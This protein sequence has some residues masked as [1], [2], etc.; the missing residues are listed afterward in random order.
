MQT[1]SLNMLYPFQNEWSEIIVEVN[2]KVYFQ[3]YVN[4][5]YACNTQ[6]YLK[7]VFLYLCTVYPM[8]C[9][10]TFHCD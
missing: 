1:V 2:G 3:Q 7:L 9:Y 5:L 10:L 6:N 4:Y 8:L